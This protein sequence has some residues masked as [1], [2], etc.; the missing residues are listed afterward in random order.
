MKNNSKFKN[1]LRRVKA[2]RLGQ[3]WNLLVKCVNAGWKVSLVLFGCFLISEIISDLSWHLR[4]DKWLTGSRPL[5]D[6]VYVYEY[7]D[8]SAKICDKTGDKC[9]LKG[10]KWVSGIPMRDSLTVFCDADG[11]RGFL[12][13]NTGKIEIPAKYC[14]AWHFSQGIAAVVDDSGRLGFI[15]HEG[16]VV[17]PMQFEY[18]ENDDE[19]EYVFI[20]GHCRVKD[21]KTHKWG[22]LNLSGEYVLPCDYDRL[23][24]SESHCAWLI[25]KDG[26]EGLL[27]KDLKEIFPMEYEKICF[28]ENDGQA[29]LIKDG[30][31]QLK[32]FDGT[33]IEP[34]VIYYDTRPLLYYEYDGEMEDN[35]RIQHPYLVRYQIAS[36]RYGV[37]D[38]R[39]GKVVVPALYTHISLISKDLIRAGMKW[40]D[41]ALVFTAD[42]RKVE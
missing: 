17:I 38:S 21:V 41:N 26:A 27:D 36:C 2:V 31:Q 40:S 7:S 16:K 33:V 8:G 42:G 30:V 4:N 13:I 23:S 5:S 11:K 20:D 15:D 1:C 35:I 34:F 18:D 9:I 29:Y 28:A 39:T 32:A 24:Y 37:M 10:L 6:N 12:N 19:C 22:I 14:H 25:R 3:I